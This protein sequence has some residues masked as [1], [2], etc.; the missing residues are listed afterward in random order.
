MSLLDDARDDA[1]AARAEA[2]LVVDLRRQLADAKRD[3]DGYEE[4]AERAERAAL[5]KAQRDDDPFVWNRSR[6]RSRG[7]Y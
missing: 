1:D 3:R 5:H 2:K 4:A 7:G 6:L